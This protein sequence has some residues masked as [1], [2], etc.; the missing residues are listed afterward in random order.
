MEQR[1]SCLYRLQ[2]T[3]KR[4]FARKLTSLTYTKAKKALL[5]LS[6]KEKSWKCQFQMERIFITGVN[7]ECHVIHGC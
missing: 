6:N 1:C 3:K 5:P 7:E 2:S 4:L